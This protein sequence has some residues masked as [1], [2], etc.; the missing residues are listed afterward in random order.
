M[1]KVIFY[2]DGYNFYHGH[3]SHTKANPDWKN[4]YWIDF[5]KLFSQFVFSHDGQEL[6]KVKYFTA[7][8]FDDSKRGKQNALLGANKIL[9]GKK[10]KVINGH[11]SE[12]LVECK[13]LCRE[14]FKVL[15]EKCSDIN[16]A[17]NIMQ[18]CI[19]KSV[20][21]VVI[22]TADSDHLSTI[23]L[24]KE[25][26]PNVKVRLYFPPNRTSRKLQSMINSVVHLENHEDKFKNAIMPAEVSKE[27]KKYIKPSDWK[28]SSITR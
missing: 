8:P 13:A 11:Y 16:L 15:E 1:K 27:K 24:L 28:K 26:F 9:H 14:D 17:L 7:V 20:D 18:D 6:H 25:K 23:K 22:I 4:Y 2:V 19:D 12:K 5:V 21:I 3:K 10:F